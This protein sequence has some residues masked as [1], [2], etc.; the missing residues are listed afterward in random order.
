MVYHVS[1]I[2]P[3]DSDSTFDMDYYLK[4]H[5]PLVAKSWG[6]YGF[7]Q[8][9]V[10]Q[11]NPNPVDSSEPVFSVKCDL[12]FKDAASYKKALESPEAGDVFGDVPKFSNKGPHLVAGDVKATVQV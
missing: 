11:Y 8:Y 3:K 4:T 7:Q 2:Y 9:Q 6:Q 5:M 10:I 12:T 1:V